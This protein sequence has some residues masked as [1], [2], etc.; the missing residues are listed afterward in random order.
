[1][2]VNLEAK[3]IKSKRFKAPVLV[4]NLLKGVLLFAW[5]DV[6]HPAGDFTV[7][8][9]FAT[10]MRAGFLHYKRL[11]YLP[12][13]MVQHDDDGT[14]NGQLRSIYTDED[15]IRSDFWLNN[16]TRDAYKDG[17]LGYV[18]PSFYDVWVCPNTGR[19][20]YFYLTEV[21]LVSRPHLK[22]IGS[23]HPAYSLQERI[24]TMASKKRIQAPPK[25]KATQL[26]STPG[27][28][29]DTTDMAIDPEIE[30]LIMSMMDQLE[31]QDARISALEA[32]LS[33]EGEGDPSE[34]GEGEGDPTPLEQ[35]AIK[36]AQARPDLEPGEVAKLARLAQSAP[37]LF[38]KMCASKGQADTPKARTQEARGLTG[39]GK[40]SNAHITLEAAEIEITQE[41]KNASGGLAPGYA[42]VA[43]A[44]AHKYPHLSKEILGK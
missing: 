1:M 38:E 26:E 3:A 29:D 17:K 34:S 22:N 2:I 31:A 23:I 6:L 27:E 16:E 5:G 13:L 12:P 4:G 10:L 24:M 36:L 21:S 8:K 39:Q 9:R 15:G 18:S 41:L 28:T 40:T 43:K 42:Q 14:I 11:G 33:G 20:L 35:A 44:I 37:K 7:D 30:A 32:A 19:M 25:S